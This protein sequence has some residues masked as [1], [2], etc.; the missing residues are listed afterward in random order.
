MNTLATLKF[1][2]AAKPVATSTVSPAERRRTALVSRIDEQIAFVNSQINNT[3]F[4]ATRTKT[5]VNKETGEKSKQTAAKLVRPWYW[6]VNKSFF[7]AIRYGMHTLQFAKGANAIEAP[8]LKGVVAVLT[9]VKTAVQAGELDAAIEAVASKR[10]TKSD[11][12]A[13]AKNA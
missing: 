6:Q 2:T 12:K 10:A 8:S 13:A 4:E 7:V 11:K 5:V 9:T 1:V 3:K